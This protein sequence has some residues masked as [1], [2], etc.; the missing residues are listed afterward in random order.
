MYAQGVWAVT[1]KPEYKA[2]KAIKLSI[3]PQVLADAKALDINVSAEAE[4]GI[5]EAVRAEK[6]RSWQEAN[7]D[8]IESSNA[9][10]EVHGLPL[11]RYRMF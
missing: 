11:A 6:N 10:V 8:A 5:V 7:R 9:Y 3:D 4:V 2:R 1:A